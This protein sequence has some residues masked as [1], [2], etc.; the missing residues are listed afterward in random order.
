MCRCLLLFAL[1][2]ALMAAN[3][4]TPA[5]LAA[6][7]EFERI[8]S[9]PAPDLRQTAACIQ[10]QAALLPVALPADLPLIHYRKGYCTLAGAVLT[11]NPTDFTAAAA[12]FDLAISTAPALASPA[13]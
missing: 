1:V 5:M 10:T 8:E 3:Q 13:L 4:P 12:E 2:S 7:A 6:Q 11:Q 9:T